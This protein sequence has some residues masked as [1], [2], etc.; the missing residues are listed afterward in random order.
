[1]ICLCWFKNQQESIVYRIHKST[2]LVVD[3]P[4]V[5]DVFV[6]VVVVV[7]VV[8]REIGH[9]R[10]PKQTR[11][12]SEIISTETFSVINRPPPKKTKTTDFFL[13]LETSH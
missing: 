11:N 8:R 2:L 3:A 6:V 12:E 10:H 5:V 9:P 13:T 7:V 1:M 4:V